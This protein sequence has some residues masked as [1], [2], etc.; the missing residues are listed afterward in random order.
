MVGLS[1]VQNCHVGPRGGADSSPE[2]RPVPSRPGRRRR[3]RISRPASSRATRKNAQ[4]ETLAQTKVRIRNSSTGALATE[5]TT[6]AA[7]TF[8]RRGPAGSYIVE[9]LGPT[10]YGDRVVAV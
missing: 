7:G 2:R 3:S 1:H 9:V 8:H 5:L 10:G 6:D 4:G